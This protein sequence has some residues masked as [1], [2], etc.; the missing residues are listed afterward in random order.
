MIERDIFE[1]DDWV[2]AWI[3]LRLKMIQIINYPYRDNLLVG[4][5]LSLHSN[6]LVNKKKLCLLL[7]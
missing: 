7:L 2:F 4:L 5:I 1:D 3:F 6:L